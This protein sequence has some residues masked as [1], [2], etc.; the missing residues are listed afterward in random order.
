MNSP[1]FISPSVI[2]ICFHFFPSDNREKEKFCFSNTSVFYNSKPSAPS[3]YLP[4]FP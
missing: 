1:V 4:V 3:I 2:F